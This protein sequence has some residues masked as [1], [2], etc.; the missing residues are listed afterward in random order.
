MLYIKPIGETTW[1][2]IE[3]F[4]QQKLPE[5]AYLDYKEDFPK[6]LEKTISAMANT[7]GGI[8]LIGVGEDDENKPVVPIAGIPFIR[9]LSERV[10]NIILSNITPPLFPEINICMNSGGTRAVV[11]VRI[12]QSHQSPHAIASNTK[13]YLR[14]GNRNKPEVLAKIDDI[15]WLK[16]R[17]FR[18]EQLREGLY[19]RALQRFTNVYDHQLEERVGKEKTIEKIQQGWLT[20]SLC[21]LYPKE[22]FCTPPEIRTFMEK[23]TVHDYYS[24]SN[25]PIC[26]NSY[27]TIVQD[28]TVFFTLFGSEWVSHI[29]LNCFGLYLYRQ[30]LLKEDVH[31]NKT[32]R[33]IRGGEIFSRVDEF[34]DSGIN[35][36]REL[37]Y[38]GF[39]LFKLHLGNVRECV[40][41]LPL[42]E[43][44]RYKLY[45]SPDE[46]VLFSDVILSGALPMEK[47]G[48]ILKSA[49][50]IAWTFG[51]DIT[52]KF[53]NKFYEKL[54]G[55]KD[56]F[57][58][59]FND[60]RRV[61]SSVSRI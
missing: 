29:E 50:Q 58:K 52:T 10:M 47:P 55:K 22:M 32:I 35:Y 9:G 7:L 59:D 40:F 8:I 12:S 26:N 24:K 31:N 44:P 38:W 51:L 53:L 16:N 5:G 43:D 49:Q 42:R 15:E 11:V 19:E 56:F 30:S 60:D 45:Y 46:D 14:T 48:L 2:D 23:I 25:F 61:F 27:G 20:L 39:L 36:Y 21:P 6:H 33:I 57:P 41:E 18:S 3:N 34:I 28:G 1:D 4:C 54:K 13:I 37:G 17:R